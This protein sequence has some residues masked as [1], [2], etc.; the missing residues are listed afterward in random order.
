MSMLSLIVKDIVVKIY[1][2]ADKTEYD[3]DEWR[4]SSLITI[5]IVN[6]LHKDIKHCDPYVQVPL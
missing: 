5:N 6:G 4:A 1:A 2:R 3:N